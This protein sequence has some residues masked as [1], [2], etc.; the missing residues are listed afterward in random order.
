MKPTCPF[1]LASHNSYSVIWDNSVFLKAKLF[2]KYKQTL[3]LFMLSRWSALIR[4][5]LSMWRILSSSDMVQSKKLSDNV[6]S[7][8]R[9]ICSW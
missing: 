1:T 9:I 5:Y 7:V 6:L 3:P 8:D 2:L 4:L